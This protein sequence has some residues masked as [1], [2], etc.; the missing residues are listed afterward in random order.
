[1]VV[2]QGRAIN[3]HG[4][5]RNGAARR[6]RSLDH[7]QLQHNLYLADAQSAKVCHH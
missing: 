1:M 3:Y 4:T 2:L 5:D 6:Q 7:G